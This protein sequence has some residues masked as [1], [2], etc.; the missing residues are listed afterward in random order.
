MCDA[1]TVVGCSLKVGISTLSNNGS[2]V[3]LIVSSEQLAACKG[4]CSLISCACAEEVS[5]EQSTY[6]HTHTHKTH[7]IVLRYTTNASM[8]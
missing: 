8:L 6:T 2:Q 5:V 1:N 3:V 7:T 4:V